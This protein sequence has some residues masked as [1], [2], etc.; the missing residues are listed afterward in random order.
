MGFLDT[1]TK[2]KK[3]AAGQQDVYQYDDIPEPLRNQVIHILIDLFGQG[4][5]RTLL[6]DVA[7]NPIWNDLRNILTRE[8]GSFVLASRQDPF[9]DCLHFIS[10]A[11]TDDVLEIVEM[12]FR[13]ASVLSTE[14]LYKC[15]QFGAR[16]SREDAVEELNHRFREQAVGFQL[17]NNTI[18]RVDSAYVHGE[19]VVPALR[20]LSGKGF[21]GALD[22]FLQAHEYYRNGKTKEAIASA[23]K[24]FES[25]LK[26]ICDQRKWAYAKGDTAKNLLDIVVA[27]GLI[28]LMLQSYFTGLRS[29]LESGLPTI[30]NATSRHGQGSQV[31][32]VPEAMAAFALHLCASSI[33]FLVE[34]HQAS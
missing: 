13:L 1:Y 26:A 20:L 2:R 24:A 25:T 33:V 29:A 17:E 5:G 8:R 16:H 27:E 31:K 10:T 23:S 21:Q 30:G 22:E 18:V 15:K 4:S 12:A 7:T 9:E 28:P 6:H 32:D 11:G 3:R 34:A 19:I 14:T